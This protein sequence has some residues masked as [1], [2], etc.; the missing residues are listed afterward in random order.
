MAGFFHFLQ[1]SKNQI[2][3]KYIQKMIQRLK[4]MEIDSCNEGTNR[5]TGG[6][7]DCTD[8][9]GDSIEICDGSDNNCD[10]IIDEGFTDGD[11]VADCVD[12]DDDNDGMSD[13]TDNCPLVKPARIDGA[14]HVYYSDIWVAYG[15]ANSDDTI[16]CQDIIF[17]G[18][19]TLNADK[20]L[21][22]K[23]GL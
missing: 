16:Q 15:N 2:L 10:A 4:N 1:S 9:T 3:I 18:D 6:S 21:T 20:T 5:C 8:T 14:S 23:G 22:I 12:S 19:M 13:L 11:G 17:D 7:L